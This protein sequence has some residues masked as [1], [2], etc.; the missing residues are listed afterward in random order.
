VGE[1]G[2]LKMLPPRPAPEHLALA[3]SSVLDGSCSGLDPCAGLYICTAKLGRGIPVVTSILR[4]F[5]GASSLSSSAS[6]PDPDS[7]NN[8]LEI[9]TSTCGE[10]AEDNHLVLMVILNGD[11]S[12]NSSSRYLIIRRSEASYARTLSSGLVQNLNLDFN[13][14]RVQAIMETIQRMAPDG[15]PLTALA[16]QGVEVVNLV[17]VEKSIGVPR[18]EPSVGD[19][20]WARHG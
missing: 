5:T 20:D 19:N 10:P 6:T 4:P 2:N 1:D 7:S 12:H 17:I 13:D 15:S 9:G 3:S 8:Y 14:I 18:R 11:R 16:Q